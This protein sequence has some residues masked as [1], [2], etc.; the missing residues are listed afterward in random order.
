MSS[1]LK[2]TLRERIMKLLMETKHPLSAKDIIYELGLNPSTSEREIYQ[3]IQH[4][5]KSIRRRSGG[6]YAVFMIPPQCRSCGYVFKDLDKPKKPSKCPKCRS[7]RIEPPRFKIM[8][9]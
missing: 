3:H 9:L 6:K 5:A 2:E 7:Q 4:I 8:E 1:S